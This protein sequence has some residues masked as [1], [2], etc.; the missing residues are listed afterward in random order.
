VG[1]RTDVYGLGAIL[2]EILTGRVPF[3]GTDTQ[4]LLQRVIHE[5]PERPRAMVPAVSPALEAV[6]LQAASNRRPAGWWPRR[7][8]TTAGPTAASW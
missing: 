1:E 2:Y 6:C 8:S 5:P 4:E 3:S 7:R